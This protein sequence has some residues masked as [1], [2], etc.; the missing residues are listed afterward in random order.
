M[1]TPAERDAHRQRMSS[2]KSY[3]ECK[4]YMDKHHEEMVARAKEKGGRPPAS[5]RRDGCAGLKP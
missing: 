3:D 1:M 4:A 2:M 5:P